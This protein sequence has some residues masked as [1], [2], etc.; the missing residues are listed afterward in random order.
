MRIRR[1]SVLMWMPSAVHRDFGVEGD[2]SQGVV[3]T[4]RLANGSEFD[5][6]L[7]MIGVVRSPATER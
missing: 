5:W 6:M 2:N 3:S 1:P 4:F 7:R